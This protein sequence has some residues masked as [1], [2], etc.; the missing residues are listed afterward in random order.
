MTD[1]HYIGQELGIFEHARNW[2]AYWSSEI[3]SFLTDDV[4]EV[5]AGLGVNTEFARYDSVS[6]WVCLEPDPALACRIRDRI[7]AQ[8]NLTN[9]RVQIGTTK[10]L[11]STPQFHTIIYVDV[12]EHIKEDREELDRASRLLHSRGR[13]IVLAPAHQWLYTPFD[14]A[15]GHFRRYNRSSLSACKPKNC[16]LEK[17]IYLDS[18][19]MLA[20]IAN[21][22]FLRQAMPSMR[23]I[24]F[25]DRFLVPSSKLLDTATLH[26][27]GKSILG[28]WR[29]Y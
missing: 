24:L 23:E 15:I 16:V 3:Q 17:L 28:V 1:S 8:A 11:G 18:A 6:S 21:L 19:G 2:K 22:L 13:I 29:K 25:W 14:R 9:C 7:A 10:T 12:L 5:G 26:L 20:S 27:I 4:L